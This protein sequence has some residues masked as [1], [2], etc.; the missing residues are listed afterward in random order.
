VSADNKN[1]V[2]LFR[3]SSKTRDELLRKQ[4]HEHGGALRSFL[5]SR[6]SSYDEI[7][8]IIQEVF[9][10]L[11][12]LDNLHEKFSY[13]SRSSRAFLFTAA[14]NYLVDLERKK[15]LERHY[16]SEKSWQS[17]TF[18]VESTPEVLVQAEEELKL[19]KQSILSLPPKWRKAFVLSR[20]EH[21]SY[22]QI[23]GQ[24]D[25]SV[26]TVEKYITSALI[27]LRSDRAIAVSKN[28]ITN[29]VL[30]NS[31]LDTIEGDNSD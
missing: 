5:C 11:A 25:I 23:A 30:N 21:L 31:K 9:S 8:D 16:I 27:Q 10:R 12:K 1:V 18:L 19:I 3:Q 2:P 29:E 20:F 4:Y 15:V 17:D 24:M 6:V 14:N 13:G 7:E 26:K 28:T 22:R